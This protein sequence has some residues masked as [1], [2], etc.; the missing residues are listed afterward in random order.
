L[1]A[2]SHLDHNEHNRNV[3]E[4]QREKYKKD[5]GCLDTE[6][7]QTIQE[8]PL[9]E[10]EAKDKVGDRVVETRRYKVNLPVDI[11]AFQKE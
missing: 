2:R 4:K 6:G 8:L 10:E 9:L 11:E 3:E 7:M 5:F 1:G